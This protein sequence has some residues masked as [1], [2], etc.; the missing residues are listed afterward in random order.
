MQRGDS[1]GRLAEHSAAVGSCVRSFVLVEAA[2]A[3]QRGS[4]IQRWSVEEEEVKHQAEEQVS[5]ASIS[6]ARKRKAEKAA[7]E[8]NPP[9]LELS[10]EKGKIFPKVRFFQ[11]KK[12]NCITK[13]DKGL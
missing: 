2:R 5:K 6:P 3:D 8:A 10:S 7:K 1:F 4:K 9:Y 11:R 12:G 13:I